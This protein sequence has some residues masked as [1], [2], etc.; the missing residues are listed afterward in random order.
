MVDTL[1][2][3]KATDSTPM[4]A[5]T[6]DRLLGLLEAR[7]PGKVWRVVEVCPGTVVKTIDNEE[8]ALVTCANLEAAKARGQW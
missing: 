2:Q 8:D 4:T 6:F 3:H 5:G 7:Y 1:R